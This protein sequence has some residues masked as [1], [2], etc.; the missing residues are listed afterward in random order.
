LL[1]L[2]AV[3]IWRCGASKTKGLEIRCHFYELFIE[4]S[5]I[6]LHRIY[7]QADCLPRLE[8]AFLVQ[9]RNYFFWRNDVSCL[10]YLF[11]TFK[12][13]FEVS[14]RIVF[15]AIDPWHEVIL[16][17]FYEAFDCFVVVK[18]RILSYKVIFA[19]LV[20]SFGTDSV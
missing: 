18:S 8:V 17:R 1:G 10:M 15:V 6:Y 5:S 20:A 2:G 4:E 19:K 11:V 16:T 3:R 9:T 7:I 13:F 12:S 14:F